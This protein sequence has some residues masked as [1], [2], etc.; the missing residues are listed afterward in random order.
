MNGSSM[1]CKVKTTETA[2]FLGRIKTL[3]EDKNYWAKF[4]AE[5]A[6]RHEGIAPTVRTPSCIC[7]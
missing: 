5:M 3:P 1:S 2:S 6:R 7:V 4:D